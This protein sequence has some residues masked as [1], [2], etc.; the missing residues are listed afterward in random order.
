MLRFTVE[1]FTVATVL[2]TAG[3]AVAGTYQLIRRR[4]S[5]EAASRDA[6][7][8]EPAPPLAQPWMSLSG[9]PCE[10]RSLRLRVQNCTTRP[11]AP[12]LL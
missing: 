1:V 4:P 8:S 6:P 10:R 9:L 5:K 11:R 2:A 3:H 12:E 7:L